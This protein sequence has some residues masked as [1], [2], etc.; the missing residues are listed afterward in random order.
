M[1]YSVCAGLTRYSENLTIPLKSLT[2]YFMGSAYLL[3]LCLL[4][5]S[6]SHPYCWAEKRL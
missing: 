5:K 2:I 4:P 3:N 6:L 1:H